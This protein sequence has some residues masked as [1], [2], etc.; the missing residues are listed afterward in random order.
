MFSGAMPVAV[1]EEAREAMCDQRIRSC[2]APPISANSVQNIETV[3]V[4]EDLTSKNEELNQRI[5][6][7]STHRTADVLIEEAG[8]AFAHEVGHGVL[9][10][11]LSGRG[12]GGLRDL[13]LL[14]GDARNKN[15][16]RDR[17]REVA[18][19]AAAGAGFEVWFRKH[20]DGQGN[21]SPLLA[22]QLAGA[23][24]TTFGACLRTREIANK[25]DNRTLKRGRF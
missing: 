24:H 13:R 17:G 4:I 20:N 23:T 1:T 10:R 3:S 11:L 25:T 7:A 12:S 18:A 22:N 21:A 2:R 15:H 6:D 19:A 16:R 9:H 14:C 8:L 5:D